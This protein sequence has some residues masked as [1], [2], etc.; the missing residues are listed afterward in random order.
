LEKPIVPSAEPK[1][2][3]APVKQHKEE[4]KGKGLSIDKKQKV[5]EFLEFNL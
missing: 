4:K 3:E 5:L 1:K 2:P